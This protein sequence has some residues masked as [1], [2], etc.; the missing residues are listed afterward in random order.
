[1]LQ[2][3]RKNLAEKK[4]RSIFVDECIRGIHFH[5]H[6]A[7]EELVFIYYY[8]SKDACFFIAK[9]KIGDNGWETNF[10]DS[11]IPAQRQ[12]SR[13]PN[14]E[15]VWKAKVDKIVHSDRL[16]KQEE[17]K[18]K[19]D[20][21]KIFGEIQQAPEKKLLKF[22]KRKCSKIKED[23]KLCDLRFELQKIVDD[24]PLLEELEKQYLGVKLPFFKDE[25]VYKKRDWIFKKIKKLQLGSKILSQRLLQ[26][27]QELVSLQSGDRPEITVEKKISGVMPIWK[28]CDRPSE[29]D[30]RQST[31]VAKFFSSDG[32]AYTIGKTAQE[33]DFLRKSWA[34]DEDWWIHDAS[35]PSWHIFLKTPKSEFPQMSTIKE[36][37]R[38]ASKESDLKR[39]IDIIITRVKFL[40]PIKGAP[41]SV[42]YTKEKRLRI[43]LES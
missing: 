24:I 26:A 41:G 25:P 1:M 28:N 43:I 23:I 39:E 33:N 3:F 19:F 35:R 14:W 8:D 31:S 16:L 9:R 20:A 13:S 21:A 2:F 7:T 40:R 32:S 15:E 12:L 36:V 38:A 6:D 34:V 17:L 27:E 11:W 4:I 30:G 37:V 22:L 18:E 5:L 29:K 10:S 42:R